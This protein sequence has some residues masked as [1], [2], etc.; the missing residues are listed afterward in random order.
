MS[1]SQELLNWNEATVPIGMLKEPISNSELSEPTADDQSNSVSVVD[2]SIKNGHLLKTIPLEHRRVYR[3]ESSLDSHS[4][5]GM[6][7]SKND[8]DRNLTQPISAETDDHLSLFYEFNG[9]ER[10]IVLPGMI[11]DILAVEIFQDDGTE[12]MDIDVEADDCDGLSIC[13]HDQ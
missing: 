8:Q 11:P 10:V 5:T 12:L 3:L 9:T 1:G 2:T 4:W 13:S 6:T 7:T